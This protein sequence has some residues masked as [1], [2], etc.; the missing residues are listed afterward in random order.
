MF[1]LSRVIENSRDT[2]L[3]DSMRIAA[4]TTDHAST[5]VAAA[6]DALST[7]SEAEL[8]DAWK[9]DRHGPSLAVSVQRYRVMVLSVCRR[10]CRSEADAEDAFQS[11][12]LYLA[13]NARKIRHPER[14]PGW[15]QRV[16]QRAAMATLKTASRESEPMVEPPV[17]PGVP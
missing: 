16:A 13:D 4:E 1:G 9:C 17:N 7:L 10:I 12:F 15:L 5:E 2:T 14:L 6:I 8:L 3:V 11:T